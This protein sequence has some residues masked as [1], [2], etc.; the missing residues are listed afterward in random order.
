MR[1]ETQM[2]FIG[3]LYCTQTGDD[4]FTHRNIDFNNWKGSVAL[5][6]LGFCTGTLYTLHLPHMYIKTYK[7]HTCSL[8]ALGLSVSSCSKELS[9]P[10]P[11]PLFDIYVGKFDCY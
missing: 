5:L 3:L 9:P 8:K 2:F 11:I 6:Y 4:C 1:D 7:P 10:H